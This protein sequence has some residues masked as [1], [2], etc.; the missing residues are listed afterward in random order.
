MTTPGLKPSRLLD[1][2]IADKDAK[3]VLAKFLTSDKW[4][5]T[6]PLTGESRR[7]GCCLGIMVAI[8]SHSKGKST[9]FA[10]GSWRRYGRECS[11]CSSIQLCFTGMKEPTI[12]LISMS[13]M[14]T[15]ACRGCS[16]F[17]QGGLRYQ[18]CDDPKCYLPATVPIE[19]SSLHYPRPNACSG[20][21]SEGQDHKDSLAPVILFAIPLLII[22]GFLNSRMRGRRGSPVLMDAIN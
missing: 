16:G 4:G 5:R 20:R 7:G 17:S 10:S 9:C 18:A 21:V 14:P 1:G 19:L 12:C 13:D 11:A 6:A 3:E 8:P 2:V 22:C 15:W